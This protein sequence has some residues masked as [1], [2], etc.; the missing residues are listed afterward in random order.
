[1]RWRALPCR[2]QN[3]RRKRR[4]WQHPLPRLPLPQ[5]LLPRALRLKKPVA[6]PALGLSVRSPLRSL[7][8][9]L[10]PAIEKLLQPLMLLKAASKL[11]SAG[12]QAARRAGQLLQSRV[13]T[14]SALIS[15]QG[16]Q[17]QR[18]SAYQT[19]GSLLSRLVPRVMIRSSLLR[20]RANWR[21]QNQP[22]LLQLRLHPYL[23]WTSV[24]PRQQLH[25]CRP[26]HQHR[27][28]ALLQSRQLQ[29]HQSKSHKHRLCLSWHLSLQQSTDR[30]RLRVQPMRASLQ[31]TQQL[32]NRQNWS[33]LKAWGV[34]T[35][36]PLSLLLRP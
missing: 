15:S 26:L 34:M 14:L 29:S 20:W 8:S 16:L 28:S 4:P 7:R 10:H 21:L 13:R 36:P 24:S 2:L 30:R 18:R 17:Q 9:Q 32:P 35:P 3:R 19:I 12:K 11:C 31:Q 25:M 23:S 27:R 6:D 5:P 1:M 33:H 22:L